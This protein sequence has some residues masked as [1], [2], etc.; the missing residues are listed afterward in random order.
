V[1]VSHAL[2]TYI[3]TDDV[4]IK[5]V[6]GAGHLGNSTESK[7]RELHFDWP[8]SDEIWVGRRR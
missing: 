2:S 1:Y 6:V 7:S 4:C 8:G 5:E 3:L